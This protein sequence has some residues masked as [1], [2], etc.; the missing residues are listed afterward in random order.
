[1]KYEL[2]TP[3]YRQQ[4]VERIRRFAEKI[5]GRQTL[6]GRGAPG[7]DLLSL[8]EGRRLQMAVMFI[9]ICGF[10]SRPLEAPEEQRVNVNALAVFFAEMIKVCEDYGAKVEKNTGDGLMAWFPDSEGDPPEKGSKRSVAAALTM[11]DVNGRAIS[12]MLREAGIQ[13][14]DFRIAIDWGSVTIASFGA[15]RRFRSHVAVG[16]TANCASKLLKFAGKNELVI[17]E[18]VRKQLPESWLGWTVQIAEDTGWVYRSSGEPYLA[19]K[20]N[21][22]WTH[23]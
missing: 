4:Q 9:D 7:D 8:G 16:T 19:Y 17:G 11:F 18:A 12:P 2:I 21:G 1:M 3:E 5:S 10:S 14:F 13:P 22:R 23:P 20:Y 6:L 15:E